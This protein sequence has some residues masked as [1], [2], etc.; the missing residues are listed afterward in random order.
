MFT[1][2]AQDLVPPKG[3]LGRCRIC[4]IAGKPTIA[5]VNTGT[6]LAGRSNDLLVHLLT[7]AGID[8]KDIYYTHVLPKRSHGKSP[9]SITPRGVTCTT[10]YTIYESQLLEQ[11]KV[12][13]AN[14][15]VPL[16][17]IALYALTREYQSS[18]YRGSI[19]TSGQLNGR[20]TIPTISA[21]SAERNYLFRHYIVHDFQRVRVESATPTFTPPQYTLRTSP[22]FLEAIQYIRESSDRNIIG[23]DI[24]TA[25]GELDCFSIA[26]STSDAISIPI[27]ANGS[28]CWT[29]TEEGA[30][31]YEL[32]KLLQNKKVCKVLQNGIYDASFL[33]ER[34][35][36]VIHN[37]EDTMIAQGLLYP[38][39]PKS[40]AFLNSIYTRHP[41]Y[42]DDGKQR[43]KGFQTDDKK[44][45]RYSARDSLT[46]LE[47]WHALSKDLDLAGM[48]DT[49]LS[50]VRLIHPL[51]HMGYLGAPM[52][53]PAMELEAIALERE[54][55]HL[56]IQLNAHVGYQ[57]N[58]SSPKQLCHYFYTE[59]KI[60]PYKKQGKPTTD[61]TAMRR[62]ARRG[63]K[64]AEL[65]L[66]IRK[67]QKYIS[68]YLKM[69]LDANDT[70]RGSYNP[71]GTNTGR[72]SSSSTIF[73]HGGNRQNV[74]H[75]LKQYTLVRDGFLYICLD[76]SS[77]ENR[78]VAYLG[79]ILS[80]I[81]AFEN[82]EDVHSRTAGLLYGI[83]PDDVSRIKG[84]AGI[85][86]SDKS[87]RDI[88]KLYNH[89]GNYGVGYKTLA[90]NTDTPE[91]FIRTNLERY[92][93]I[94]P[95]V[96]Q[97]FQ[98]NILSQLRLNRTL[99]NLFGRRRKFMDR[100]G[101]SLF[102]DA[103][104]FPAQS[105][106]A[107]I[108]NR[109]GVNFLYSEPIFKPVRLPNQIHDSIELEIP[110]YLPWSHIAEILLTLIQNIEQ[111]LYTSIHKF[112]IPCDLSICRGT[113]A[114]NME[115]EITRDN[116]TKFAIALQRGYEL[117]GKN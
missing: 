4:L 31:L 115:I 58:P 66:A 108:I 55:D 12:C 3:S 64:E 10:E 53:K 96:R 103:F 41:F 81:E 43:F 51:I 80:M 74:P 79:N 62:L 42:K 78:I 57:I 13:S 36:I 52:D 27:I 94:Y 91:S 90:L 44:F 20:K 17:D 8:L 106:I 68:T 48:R 98:A 23:F 65:I 25:K 72:L 110:L 87:Q 45:W 104:A 40:L 33:F 111:P 46:T 47:C 70:F 54:I 28:P 19:L 97:V 67:R 95:E 9:I 77:A 11:L 60:P 105:T 83:N 99:T 82:G 85:P 39:F 26:K 1:P 117:L 63:F 32:T 101:D 73:D 113:H 61:V 18:K 37:V 114:N 30:I 88:G 38:D 34:Y 14:V 15:F 16:D 89:S 112:T 6:P 116:P 92:H 5:E 29:V 7:T 2:T 59:K 102:N 24:E 50:H 69:T 84:S 56:K 21:A 109:R 100:W 35:G 49:Y 107:D 71:I 76:L 22:S 93:L 86:N 75:T